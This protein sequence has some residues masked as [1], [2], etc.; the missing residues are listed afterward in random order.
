MEG[1]IPALT[2]QSESAK[3]GFRHLQYPSYFGN[4]LVVFKVLGALTLIIPQIP[5]RYKDAAYAGFVFNFIFA[6][7]S[8]FAIDGVN[9]Q[10]FF[11]PIF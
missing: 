11:P 2:S 7:V 3:Q 8:Q 5:K 10:S 9:F 4:V 6:S 1:I